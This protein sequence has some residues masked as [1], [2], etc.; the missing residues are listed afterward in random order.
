MGDFD[1]GKAEEVAHAETFER[2]FLAVLRRLAY[3][4]LPITGE[5]ALR[6]GRFAA[7]HGDPFDRIIAAQALEL[8][9]PVI[10]KDQ[11]L[12]LFGVRRIW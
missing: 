8:D 5:I 1:E 6:A 3:T 11:K 2:D 9:L 7:G 4:L 12:D 10:S